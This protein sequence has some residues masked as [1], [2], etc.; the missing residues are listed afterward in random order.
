MI[1]KTAKPSTTAMAITATVPT[2]LSVDFRMTVS[3]FV[4]PGVTIEYGVSVLIPDGALMVVAVG[5]DGA[6]VVVAKGL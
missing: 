6:L 4:F 3:L 2:G 1:T 5:L